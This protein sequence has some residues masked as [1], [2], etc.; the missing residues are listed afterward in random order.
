[1]FNQVTVFETR[2]GREHDRNNNRRQHDNWTKLKITFTKLKK[3]NIPWR[4]D[5]II[6]SMN[7]QRQYKNSNQHKEMH[8]AAQ[9]K[10]ES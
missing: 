1:M 10:Q 5:K 3:K 8:N 7:Q 6:H 9:R 2:K 4:T